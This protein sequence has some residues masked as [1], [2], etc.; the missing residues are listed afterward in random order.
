MTFKAH[1]TQL[2]RFEDNLSGWKIPKF[3][4]FNLCIGQVRPSVVTYPMGIFHTYKSLGNELF[5]FLTL[6]TRGPFKMVQMCDKFCTIMTCCIH[7]TVTFVMLKRHSDGEIENHFRSNCTKL[8]QNFEFFKFF[9]ILIVCVMVNGELFARKCMKVGNKESWDPYQM[10][11]RSKKSV[12]D[13]DL[14]LEWTGERH[15]KL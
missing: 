6:W 1:F 3:P 15:K 4:E 8:N 2:L 7:W 5:E 13:A 11:L 14:V 12:L 9:K 10:V